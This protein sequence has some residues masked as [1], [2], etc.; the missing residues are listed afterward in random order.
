[1]ASKMAFSFLLALVIACA[2]TVRIPN[3]EAQ[4]FLPCQTTKDCEYLHCSSGT[5]LCVNKQW[6]CTISL[7]HQAKLDNLKNPMTH[8]QTCKSTNDCD[9]R[10]RFTCASRSYM[11]FDGLCT[12]TN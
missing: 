5:P 6:Q 4:I 1:M 3:A 9:P 10:M 12:C 11:C 2:M 7:T 8:A